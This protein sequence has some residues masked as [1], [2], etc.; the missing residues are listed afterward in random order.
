ML[1]ARNLIHVAFDNINCC[2]TVVTATMFGKVAC[3]FK[4]FE[5]T[6]AQAAA[7]VNSHLS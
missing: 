3:N 4:M 5:R 2:T 7:S 6:T 1:L